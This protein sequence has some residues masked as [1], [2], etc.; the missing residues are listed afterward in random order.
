MKIVN[1][2]DSESDRLIVFTAED[3]QGDLYICYQDYPEE[4]VWCVNISEFPFMKMGQPF[5]EKDF[6]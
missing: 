1:V 3:G 4:S 5:D 6:E 2:Y